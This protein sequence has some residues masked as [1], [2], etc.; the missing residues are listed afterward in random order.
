[1]NS[2]SA[3]GHFERAAEL[4]NELFGLKGLKKKIVWNPRAVDRLAELA[5]RYGKTR[6]PRS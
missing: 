6:E 1:M 4:R 5:D 2:E 3:L